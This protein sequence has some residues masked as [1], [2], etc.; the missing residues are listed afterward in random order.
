MYKDIFDNI[1][2]IQVKI[3]V[4]WM[5]SHLSEG[6]KVRPIIVSELDIKATDKADDLAKEAAR[7]VQIP[8]PIAANVINKYNLVT[9]IPKRL[10]AII[11]W[12]PRRKTSS[13]SFFGIQP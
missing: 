11:C 10:I 4:R 9:K 6:K 12:L 8:T 1:D 2:N 7:L 13:R 3:E 5:P